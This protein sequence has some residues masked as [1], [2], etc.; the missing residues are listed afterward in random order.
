MF[1]FLQNKDGACWFSLKRHYASISTKHEMAG[2]SNVLYSQATT[3]TG[4]HRDVS[5]CPQGC[6][7]ALRKHLSVLH[8]IQQYLFCFIY[9]SIK[10][11]DHRS[12]G[13]V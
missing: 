12:E 6:E 3:Q 8:Q 13:A 10:K 7:L 1:L 11:S 2:E 5:D 4:T 9:H